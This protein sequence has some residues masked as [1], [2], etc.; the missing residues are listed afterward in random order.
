MREQEHTQ[1]SAKGW[2]SSS[3]NKQISSQAHFLQLP[4]SDDKEA[5]KEYWKQQE[6][7]WRTEPEIDKKRQKYLNE[8]R[9]ISPDIEQGIYPFRGVKLNRADVEWLLATH[10]NGY[11]PVD[12]SDESQRNRQ[13]LDFR[14]ADLRKADLHNLPLACTRFGP[15][16]VGAEETS[17]WYNITSEQQI[18]AMAHLE[19]ANLKCAHLEGAHL[20]RAYLD[21]AFLVGVHF[22][23]ANMS[24]THLE[25]TYAVDAHFEDTDLT[26][27]H[28][29]RALLA[30]AHFDRA[31]LKRA[32]FNAGTSLYNIRLGHKLTG[33]ASLAE[34][35]WGDAD[36]TV[37]DWALVN[38][39]GDEL[40]A[41]QRKTS[42]GKHKV[43]QIRIEEHETAVRA[44]RQLAVVLEGQG[45]NERAAYF[46]YRAQVLQRTV[47]KLQA[48]QPRVSLRQRVR[49]SISYVSS[50]FLDLLAGYGYR[51]ARSVLWYLVIIFA[52]AATYF[53]AGHLQFFP[54]SLVFSLTSFHGRG[55]FPGLEKGTSLHN[56]LVV[57]AAFEAVIG[58]FIEISFIATFTKRFFGS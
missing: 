11:G 46:A 14:G 22:E 24:G 52:F 37:I 27:A 35:H 50:F 57:L 48:L 6:Q 17:Q 19:E 44:N 49:K 47:L 30:G 16:W 28:F 33:F 2:K 42:D 29:E 18:A 23:H 5:W 20:A 54:D 31:N 13:G 45:M 12:W 32:F 55:F 15:T 3:T 40:K 38:M 4:T 8:R 10:E 56:P 58:L 34:V 25:H 7:P 1:A 39:L 51:P 26:W 9:S 43:V 53:A 21:Y 36:L 41:H